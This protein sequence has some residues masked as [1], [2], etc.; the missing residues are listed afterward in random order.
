MFSKSWYIYI[1]YS[2]FH[3]T[4]NG[5]GQSS[6]CENRFEQKIKETRN[7]FGVFHSWLSPKLDIKK[8]LILLLLLKLS[9]QSAQP[10]VEGTA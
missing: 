8:W 4:L 9:S 2:V 1:Y 3:R 10:D 7:M 6:L 5:T